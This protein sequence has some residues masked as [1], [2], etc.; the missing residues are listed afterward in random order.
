MAY[1]DQY[2]TNPHLQSVYGGALFK[3]DTEGIQRAMQGANPNRG[4]TGF[5]QYGTP[6]SNE[7]GGGLLG[8]I[9][10]AMIGVGQAPGTSGSPYSQT[11]EP[12]FIPQYGTSSVTVTDPQSS[13][14]QL[15]KQIGEELQ[16]RQ[17]K[18][19]A[20]SRFAS[21]PIGLGTLAALGVGFG[22]AGLPSGLGS[23]A[24]SGGA[25]SGTLAGSAGAGLSSSVPTFA[26]GSTGGLF[27]PAAGASGLGSF[28]GGAALKG[29]ALG[30]AQ[31]LLKGG[32]LKSAL[33]G[34]ALGGLTG[35]FSPGLA[36]SLRG[37]G[38]APSI[39]SGAAGAITGGL[40]GLAQDGAQGG[41]LG[42]L[43]GGLSGYQ[44]AP[45][46]VESIN[47]G[48][49]APA[50]ITSA[51]KGLGMLS[52]YAN[53]LA[54]ALS[55]YQTSRAIEE[56]EDDLV[57]AQRRALGEYAPYR[58]AGRDATARLQEELA[59]GGIGG[60]YSFQ[61][62]PGYQFQL[63]QGEQALGR[64]QSA[65][66]NRFSGQALREATEYG[67]GLANQAYQ[68]GFDR[69]QARQL[70]LYNLLAGQQGVGLGAAGQTAG[71]YDALGNI[72]AAARRGQSENLNRTL[73]EILS[74]YN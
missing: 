51:T 63:A 41:L 10:P 25:G 48:A 43:G 67:Q 1:G 30:G 49:S 71:L 11:M 38:L 52:K 56:S 27:A 8:Y 68:Q 37:L 60:E 39:A 24:I 74:G 9:D 61:E 32:D 15:N 57:E 13:G 50:P 33:S 26:A 45:Q 34:A 69:D 66:G 64:A 47:W 73:A 59:S 72:S 54:S 62:D 44:S 29:A 42:A 6:L 17:S 7:G 19:G 4:A 18:G 23:G 3:G 2:L 65:R 20:F 58:G 70:N 46:G 14:F 16:R 36:Q 31:G 12:G 55:G 35:G 22:A 40:S 5:D 21:S 28:A 53:P